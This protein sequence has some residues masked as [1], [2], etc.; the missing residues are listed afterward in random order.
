LRKRKQVETRT[1]RRVTR[2]GTLDEFD[3][4]RLRRRN[5][6]DPCLSVLSNV[7]VRR[8]F[9]GLIGVNSDGEKR[10]SFHNDRRFFDVKMGV[11]S[12]G[13]VPE[14]TEVDARICE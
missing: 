10:E 7:F 1:R 13:F 3:V 8:R 11:E 9:V 6:S 4:R 14:S 12:A 5:H 2:N